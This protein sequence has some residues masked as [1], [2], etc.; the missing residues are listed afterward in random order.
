MSIG[1]YDKRGAAILQI[2]FP[3]TG[4]RECD[5]VKKKSEDYMFENGNNLGLWS[6]KEVW[7]QLH[8]CYKHDTLKCPTNTLVVELHCG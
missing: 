3:F 1:F 2:S 5:Y 7:T 6:N 8:S 4:I